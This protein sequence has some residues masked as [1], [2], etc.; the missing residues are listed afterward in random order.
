MPAPS[1]SNPAPVAPADSNLGTG[2]DEGEVVATEACL[3]VRTEKTV[4][5]GLKGALE[6]GKS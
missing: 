1:S 6:V 4:H 2:L 3:D 5:E